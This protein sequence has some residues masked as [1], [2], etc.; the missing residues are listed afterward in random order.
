MHSC[1]SD[2]NLQAS[3]DYG[4]VGFVV[5]A[6]LRLPG[7]RTRNL[8]HVLVEGLVFGPVGRRGWGD[9]LGLGARGDIWE[10]G[11]VIKVTCWE[12]GVESSPGIFV[13]VRQ[14]GQ[15]TGQGVYAVPEWVV[16]SVLVVRARGLFHSRWV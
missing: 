4:N 5:G 13:L 15:L 10:G 11:L 1:P 8:L 3:L 6:V 16:R 14:T 9:S 7:A 2:P 12:R